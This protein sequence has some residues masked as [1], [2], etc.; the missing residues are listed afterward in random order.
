MSLSG[1]RL[2]ILASHPIQYYA[3]LYRE[4]AKTI[5]LEVM[6]AHRATPADQARAGFGV[7]FDW[8]IEL[9]DGYPSRFLTN[10]SRMPGS[11]RFSGCD[12]PD[13]GERLRQG[14]FDALMVLGWH[15]KSYVQGI[16]AAKRRRLPVLVRG[17][18]QLATPRSALRRMV[19][20]AAFPALLRMFDAALYVG[21]RS[22]AYYHHYGYPSRQLFFSPH[23]VDNAWFFGRATEAERMRIRNRFGIGGD[24]TLILFAGKLVAFK[25][26][27][28]LIGAAALCRARGERIE[29]LIAGDGELRP[30]LVIAAREANVPLHMLGFCNQTEMPAAYAAADCLVL[31]SDE[32]ETWGL[33]ANEALACSRPIIVSDA[34]G[35]GDDLAR[36]GVVGRVFPLGNIEALATAIQSVRNT[37]PPESSIARVLSAHSLASAADGIHQALSHL[38]ARA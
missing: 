12:T 25:R 37:L 28:D 17:D 5:D 21:Q 20:T 19:K 22:R 35:C 16:M 23:C 7:A 1:P 10:V 36:D 31:P 4:L 15:L 29:I 27:Q 6:F 32:R 30:S 24:V 38:G 26:P 14:R 11:D 9:T 2:A 8:D 34:C 3:P 13:I 33:V 18:S